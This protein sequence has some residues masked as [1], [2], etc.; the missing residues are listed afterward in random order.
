MKKLWIVTGLLVLGGCAHNQQ[1]VKNPGQTN[2]SFR[3]DMLYC[4]GE[5]TGAWNDRNGV[6]KMNIYKGEMGAISYEDCMRQLG[7][8]QAY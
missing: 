4:K 5:A 3:N 1:F 6:S 8:K 2:D 7:Y